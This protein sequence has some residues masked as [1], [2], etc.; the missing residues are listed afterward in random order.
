MFDLVKLGGGGGGEAGG[1]I[2]LLEIFCTQ[3]IRISCMTAK[4]FDFSQNSIAY[5]AVCRFSKNVHQKEA[6]DRLGGGNMF[7]RLVQNVSMFM[8]RWIFEGAYSN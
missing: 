3:I 6:E 8:E 7:S 2:R 1:R 5:R 4:I